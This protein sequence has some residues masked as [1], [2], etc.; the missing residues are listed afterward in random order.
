MNKKLIY[1]IL[2]LVGVLLITGIVTMSVLCFYKTHLQITFVSQNGIVLGQKNI[3]TTIINGVDYNKYCPLGYKVTNVKNENNRILA[4]IDFDAYEMPIISINTE[5]NAE[6][7]DKENYVTSQ[8]SITNCLDEFKKD[9]AEAGVRL[10]GNSTLRAPKKAYRIKFNKREGMLG[11]NNNA[12]CKSWV[13]LADYYDPSLLRNYAM[14]TFAKNLNIYS[15]DCQHVELYLNGEYQGVY[16]LAEHMQIDKYRINIEEYD[17]DT[18]DPVN[19]GY[20]LENEDFVYAEE[21][22]YFQCNANGIEADYMHWVIKS[23]TTSPE[24]IAYIQGYMQQVYDA[25]FNYR[26]EDIKELIDIDSAIERV[27]IE[28]FMNNIDENASYKVW[29]DKD[30]KLTFGAPWDADAAMACYGTYQGTAYFLNHLTKDMMLND[31]FY[32]LVETR[33]LELY[34]QGKF[35]EWFDN[36]ENTTNQYSKSFTRN[37]ERWDI[38]GT[39]PNGYLQSDN[40][41]KYKT[42]KDAS[43]DLVEWLKFRIESLKTIHFK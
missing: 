3:E 2:P 19:T 31:W 14:F 43:K 13:L 11:L 16:L 8:V 5:N 6:I 32:Q 22:Y 28:L 18:S 24:Q 40:F 41:L 35:T 4:I 12:K 17:P 25:V 39:K 38:L 21:E 37:F 15:S 26:E 30:G 29:K 23:D 10:R 42:H 7:L 36:I 1:I 20:L 33:W 27:I 9:N 34:N